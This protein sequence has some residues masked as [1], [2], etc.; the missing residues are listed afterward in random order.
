MNRTTAK[1]LFYALAVAVVTLLA[2]SAWKLAS[3]M[4]KIDEVQSAS[5]DLQIRR[6]RIAAQLR[7]R[8]HRMNSTLFR[9]QVTGDVALS[10]RFK[11]LE[12]QLTRF[13]DERRP[14][15]DSQE[16]KEI[17]Q[18]IEDGLNLYLTEALNL[19]SARQRGDE[20]DLAPM[21]IERIIEM[22]DETVELTNELAVAR[23]EAFRAL[24]Q[25]YR[26]S[27]RGLQRT[28]LI[29]FLLT[30][31]S[32]AG[33]SW[34][35]WKVFFSPMRLELQE[36]RAFA[37]QREELANIGTL[38]SGIAHEIRN[39]ITAM[40]ARTFALAEL[41]EPGSPAAKQA[42][43]I[44]QELN[45]MERVVRDFLDFA[46]P[47]EP[48]TE[49]TRLD[50]FLAEI[51]EFVRPEMEE[52]RVALEQR[53]PSGAEARIDPGQMK[54]VILNLVR[55]AAEACASEGGK[56]SLKAERGGG[57]ARI[58]ISD[59]GGGIPKEFRDQLF[60]PF[61]SKKHGGTGLGLP[62]ART[63]VRKHGGELTFESVE[64]QGSRFII[65]LD[66][67]QGG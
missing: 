2:T 1:R 61:F 30:M 17:L 7:S 63:I 60:V 48:D 39:P 35:A 18:Q 57:K 32:A 64:G 44:D 65:E 6:F 51:E 47:A 52:R 40:K 23:S 46:R 27:V 41:V 43:V 20:S 34:M 45:R 67:A 36:A 42:Q 3:A 21:R 54:Q 9:H 55:N 66:T 37:G 31:A 10:K 49:R 4:D 26:N 13:I 15:L 11:S 28:V 59:N 38:A 56:V 62:I 29:S 33:L 16:E 22:A 50:D 19:M 25:G 58:S 14:L 53:T 24:L 8:I 12:T 5:D